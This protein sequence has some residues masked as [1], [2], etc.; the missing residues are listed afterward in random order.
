MIIQ[1]LRKAIYILLEQNSN[2]LP[3]LC[4]SKYYI[5]IKLLYLF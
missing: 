2:F 1:W 3:A 4:I 5:L